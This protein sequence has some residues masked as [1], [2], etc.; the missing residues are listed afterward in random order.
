LKNTYR[1][2]KITGEKVYLRE[3]TV[4]D[5]SAEYCSWL[6][7]PE[8]HKYLQTRKTT[9]GGLRTYVKKQMNDPNSLF[10]GVFD[11]KTDLHI[12][13]VKLEP[14]DWEKKTTTFGLLIGNKD[15]WGKGIGTEVTQLI[16]NFAF[17]RLG[18]DEV[19]LG[20][21]AR[22]KAAIRIYE[23]AGFE[24]IG[25]KEQLLHDGTLRDDILMAIRNHE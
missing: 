5:V 1:K 3:L 2:E 22:N 10:F 4:D 24:V 6:N 16:I 23:K 12:G 14:F 8:V 21:D 9:L 18:L 20:V 19:K 25:R 7:D 15:Y 11:K 17:D 13:N